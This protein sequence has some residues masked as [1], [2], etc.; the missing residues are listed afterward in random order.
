MRKEAGPSLSRQGRRNESVIRSERFRILLSAD[1]RTPPCGMRLNLRCHS[2]RATFMSPY[3]LT[4]TFHTGKKKASRYKTRRHGKHAHQYTL[5]LWLS[6]STA[7]RRDQL[8]IPA[9]LSGALFRLHLVY[10]LASFDVSGQW[11]VYL[12]AAWPNEDYSSCT[13]FIHPRYKDCQAV[14]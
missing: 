2:C 10:P 12:A 9:T 14:R 11:P 4:A 3:V 7:H 1:T 8:P 13:V 6:F 5:P